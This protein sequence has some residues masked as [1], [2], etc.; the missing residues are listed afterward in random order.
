MNINAWLAVAL[1]HTIT[2]MKTAVRQ[3]G[4]TMLILAACDPGSC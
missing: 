3:T 4:Q 2:S 1:T